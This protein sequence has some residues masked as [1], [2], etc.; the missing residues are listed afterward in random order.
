VLGQVM[1]SASTA[2]ATKGLDGASISDIKVSP[3][4]T[5]VAAVGAGVGSM[6]SAGIA[7][8]TS[9]AIIGNTVAAAG[10]PTATGVT[11]GA[12]VEGAITGGAEKVAPKIGNAAT[13]A[14]QKTHPVPNPNQ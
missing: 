13:S 3:W 1:G 10:T 8:S 9:Q 11:V 7:N 2:I 4:T 14:I 6:V 5:T 12:V